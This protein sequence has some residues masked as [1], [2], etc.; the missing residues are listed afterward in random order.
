MKFIWFNVFLFILTLVSCSVSNEGK[1]DLRRS[2]NESTLSTNRPNKE[3]NIILQRLNSKNNTLGEE[4]GFI[5]GDTLSLHLRSAFIKNFAEEPVTP[6]I[7][8]AFTRSWREPIGEIAIVANAF[9]EKNGKELGFEDLDNGRVVFYSDDVRKG[10]MINFNNMP[11]YGPLLYNGAP[12]AFRI[13]IFE[14]DITSER[15][16][17]MLD[18]IAKAGGTA[19]PPASPVLNLLNGIGKTLLNGG[20]NDTELRYTMVLDPKRGG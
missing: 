3:E 4:A 20:Q 14:L 17:A 13:A 8:N 7:T 1:V 16:K 9:E 2:N 15:V 12:F 5:V 10:Q 18:T 11:I 6:F 19:Y